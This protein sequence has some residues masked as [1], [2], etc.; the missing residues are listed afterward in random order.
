MP[1]SRL[2]TDK[3][4]TNNLEDNHHKLPKMKH[5]E[6]IEKNTIAKNYRENYKR[7][8]MCNKNTTWR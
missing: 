2:D 3:E 8:N 4:T 5:K 7:Y 6:I 1:I